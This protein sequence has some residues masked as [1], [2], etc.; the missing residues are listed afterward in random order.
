MTLALGLNRGRDAFQ[1]SR[2]KFVAVARAALPALSCT[3]PT[4]LLAP[5]QL[6]LRLASPLQVQATGHRNQPVSH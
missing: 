1:Y 5:Q 4:T 6:L 3:R 2:P